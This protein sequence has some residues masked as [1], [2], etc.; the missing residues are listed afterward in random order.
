MNLAK[1]HFGLVVGDVI[2]FALSIDLDDLDNDAADLESLTAAEVER[3]ASHLWIVVFPCLLGTL[4]LL[5]LIALHFTN[6]H[7]KFVHFAL[8]GRKNLLIFLVEYNR[9][10]DPLLRQHTVALVE[11]REDARAASLE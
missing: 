11:D 4:Q 3:V 1:T 7:P 6:D 2:D 8:R 10:A 9:L 5:V